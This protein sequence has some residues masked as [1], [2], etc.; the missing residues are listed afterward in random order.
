M[1]GGGFTKEGVNPWLVAPV[2]ALAAFMEVLDISIANVSLQ[3]IA[4]DLAAG[5]D[6]STWVL[7]SYLVTN[8]IILPVSG[9]LSTA[10]GRKRFFLACIVGFSISSLLC[11]LAPNLGMLIVF[12]AIQGLTGG[13]LQPCAQAILSDTFPPRQR[14]MA[15]ALYGM[16]VVFA[17]AIGPTLGG[18]ITDTVSWRWVFLLNVPVGIVLTM[19]VIAMVEDPPALVQARLERMK[20]KL[21]IDYLGFALLSIGFGFLQVVLDKGEQDDWFASPFIFWLS[22]GSALSLITFMIWEFGQD[23]PIVDLHLL[24]NRNFAVANVLMFVLGFILLGSTVLLP[25]MV[26]R[27]FGYT[28]TEAGWVITPGGV[29][30]I[31][32]MP[33]IGRLVSTVDSRYLISLGLFIGSMAL[34]YLTSFTLQ[35]DYHHFMMAR[36]YQ[37]L[38]LSLLFIPINTVAYRGIPQEK[39]SAASALINMSRNLGGS[40]GISLVVTVLSRQGQVHQSVLTEH[41]TPLNPAYRDT[42]ENMIALFM[43]HGHTL[44]EATTMA[45]AQVA[46]LVRQQAMMLGFID[47][48]RMLGW[49]FLVLV[50][51]VFLMRKTDPHGHEPSGH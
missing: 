45:A 51:F 33:I 18:W 7:T 20:Q 50:P 5:Q 11:G 30:I 2:V 9:W 46:G 17:P 35:T 21:K 44:A 40:F 48:F 47:D 31:F 12:R 13:G 15:F 34:F 29:A 8:A 38:G 4:G 49:M 19:L 32:I 36:I 22:V 28:A 25:E 6:E 37:A 14:G 39:S 27:L 23:D 42:T 26:Q 41:A 43:K 3:H 16:S 24:R 10:L 1:N